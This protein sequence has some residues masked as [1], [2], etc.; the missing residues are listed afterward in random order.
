MEQED[1]TDSVCGRRQVKID[2]S[3]YVVE[4]ALRGLQRR[5][6]SM[7]ITSVHLKGDT[8]ADA[9]PLWRQQAAAGQILGFISGRHPVSRV[10][11]TSIR[12]SATVI[13][14]LRSLFDHD[15][16]VESIAL[17]N[18][19]M[20]DSL[21]GALFAS[22]ATP[23]GL[24]ALDLSGNDLSDRSGDTLRTITRAATLL[25]RLTLNGNLLPARTVA[26][27]CLGLCSHP[28]LEELRLRDCGLE[29][30]SLDKLARLIERN[31]QITV[32]DVRDN[33]GL[34]KPLSLRILELLRAN[35]RR[36]ERPPTTS[37]AAATS[38]SLFDASSERLHHIL[39]E[40]SCEEAMLQSQ[41]VVEPVS[42]IKC[43]NCAALSQRVGRLEAELR[44]LHVLIKTASA[45]ENCSA[46]HI[47]PED[48][49]TSPKN[50]SNFSLIAAQRC[51]VDPPL[52]VEKIIDD[53]DLLIDASD[54][55]DHTLE[56]EP[57]LTNSY[58]AVCNNT[59]NYHSQPSDSQSQMFIF[60]DNKTNLSCIEKRANLS[61]VAE[62]SGFALDS[63]DRDQEQRSE[64]FCD[65][66]ILGQ[67]ERE[68]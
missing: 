1:A 8:R 11:M 3:R 22:G 19:Q 7:C 5:L 4:G 42:A 60:G 52:P 26:R 38:T 32:L 23:T 68:D 12:V 20:G 49:E 15:T 63:V 13:E 53:L 61:I 50:E 62:K 27:L 30:E 37:T 56:R 41:G 55:K 9:P 10:K 39:Q 29:R 46:I 36:R 51:D 35:S 16:Q 21:L 43:S 64:L 25:Y 18:C 33:A 6:D 59:L 28:R 44:R 54:Q 14:K 31:S 66:N 45:Q 2:V 40:S 24:K 58:S 34:D 48:D 65:K 57:H 47:V 17:P 67:L